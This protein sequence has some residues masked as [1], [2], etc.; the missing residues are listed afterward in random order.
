MCNSNFFDEQGKGKRKIRHLNFCLVIYLHLCNYLDF[1][2]QDLIILYNSYCF[3]VK[4]C[5][6][7]LWPLPL[8]CHYTCKTREKTLSNLKK[9][10]ASF[11]CEN[12]A[13]Y[14][15]IWLQRKKIILPCFL[16]KYFSVNSLVY[17]IYHVNFSERKGD[18]WTFLPEFLIY[19][20]TRIK[21]R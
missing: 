13:K 16:A 5:P 7:L 3:Q 19:G 2:T 18:T 9:S 6:S 15:I 4:L 1:A 12:M 8:T 14:I 10:I 11:C 21:T 20:G 17:P